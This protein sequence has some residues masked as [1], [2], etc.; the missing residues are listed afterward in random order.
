MDYLFTCVFKVGDRYIADIECRAE[1][2]FDPDMGWDIGDLSFASWKDGVSEWTLANP[3]SID[4]LERAIYSQARES[5][6]SSY[7]DD[8]IPARVFDERPKQTAF[9]PNEDSTYIGR[10]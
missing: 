6:N 1:I 5:L 10:P 8:A 3:R 7:H 9:K 2:A 4:C